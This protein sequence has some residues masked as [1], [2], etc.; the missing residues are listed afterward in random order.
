MGW[1]GDGWKERRER[2][3]EGGREAEKVQREGKGI[4]DEFNWFDRF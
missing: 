3:R 4:K 2:A 1:E